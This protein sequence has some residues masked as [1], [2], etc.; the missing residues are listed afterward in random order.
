MEQNEIYCA[1]C[2]T[3][4]EHL[5]VVALVF[6]ISDPICCEPYYEAV[7]NRTPDQSTVCARERPVWNPAY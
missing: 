5:E 2:G 7:T 1:E 6:G 3:C 4:R